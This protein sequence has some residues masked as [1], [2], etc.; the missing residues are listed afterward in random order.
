MGRSLEPSFRMAPE[1]T[2]YIN[3]N[4]GEAQCLPTSSLVLVSAFAF[5]FVGEASSHLVLSFYQ[6]GEGKV[7]YDL[8]CAPEY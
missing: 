7:E 8:Y 2:E 4:I 5:A 6:H 1:V 3:L